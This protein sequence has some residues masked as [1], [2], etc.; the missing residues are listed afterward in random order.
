MKA[1]VYTAYGATPTVTDVPAPSCPDGGVVIEVRAT[2]VCRS[3]WHA[4]RGHDPVALPHIPGHE[5]AGVVRAVGPGVT[6]WQ[7]GDR[8]TVPFVCGCGACEYCRAGDAQVCPH[9]TQ[10]G[11]TGPGSFA[12]LVPIHAADANLV[13]LPAA[14]D[15]VTAASLGCRFAT[16][17]RALTAHGRL[18]ADDWLA[19][20]GCGGLGLSAVMIGVALGARLVAV[21]G[22][23]SA[24]DRA[25]AL[26]AKHL[27]NATD[28]DP[29]AV[30]RQV[31][32]GGAA[33]SVDALGSPATA[34]ASVRG[35]RRRGRHVQAG[36]LLDGPTPLPMD[37]VVAQ[38]LSVHGTHG[39]AAADYPPLLALVADG[40]LRPDLLVGQ[41]IPLADAPAA[42]TAMGRP[43]TGPGMTVIAL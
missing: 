13:A 23:P 2:G 25:G 15:F 41:V 6:R 29:A 32:G 4:W 21:D 11:F 8:V 9:Q 30:V 26:G 24:L 18:G 16:A 22:S 27:V 36:L 33:V 5:L 31:T 28:T 1:V 10:P 37:L 19:V 34:A 20:H 12:E 17:Y 7:A 43:A 38:E 3:D 14:V 39:M 42:L 40:T 35:L